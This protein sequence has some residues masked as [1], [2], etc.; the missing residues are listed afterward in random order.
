VHAP[1]L[2]SAWGRRLQAR[3]V[4]VVPPDFDGFLRSSAAGMLH[5]AADHGVHCVSARSRSLRR[6]AAALP[7]P[8]TR[9]P[10]GRGAEAPSGDPPRRRDHNLGRSR[11][12]SDSLFRGLVL[13]PDCVIGCACGA[14]LGHLARSSSQRSHPSK[15]SPHVQPCTSRRS[16]SSAARLLA[17]SPSPGRL[18]PLL[19]SP[20]G[21][22]TAVSVSRARPQGLAPHMSPLR[23]TALRPSRA[24]SSPGLLISVARSVSLGIHRRAHGSESSPASPAWA[25][26]ESPRRTRG[27]AEIWF[28]QFKEPS[29]DESLA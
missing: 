15:V 6:L 2:P 14:P 23:L 12:D 13:R 17:L 19:R 10:W 28:V 24:R 26:E 7:D 3:S 5:P 29:E 20:K 1:P 4:L 8:R 22:P 11:F 18:P 21:A 9:R 25:S 27:A 16:R